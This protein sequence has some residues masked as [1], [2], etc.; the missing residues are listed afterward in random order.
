MQMGQNKAPASPNSV[1]TGERSGTT[2]A[3]EEVHRAAPK[4]RASC[5]QPQAQKR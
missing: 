1:W 3:S 5:L 4:G 2:R